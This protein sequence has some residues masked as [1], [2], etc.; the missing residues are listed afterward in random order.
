MTTFFKYRRAAVFAVLVL[1]GGLLYFLSS[2]HYVES[3][4]FSHKSGFYEDEF[5][6]KISAFNSGKIYYTLDGS[7]P[8]EN[9]L[10][11][12]GPIRITD[13]SKNP[14]HYSTLTNVSAGFFT[15]LIEQYQTED[16]VPG[17]K[18]PDFS[19]D[20]CTVVRAVAVNSNGDFSDTITASYFVKKKAS[21]YGCNIISL[22]TDPENLFDD[23]K[24]IYV[25]GNTFSDYLEDGEIGYDWRFWNA[26]Y[27]NRGAEWERPVSVEFFDANGVLQHYQNCGARIH[28]GVSRGTLPRSF[29]LYARM[30][31]DTSDKFDIPL[32][33]SDYLPQ[34][35][36]LNS[37]GNQLITQFPDY[38]MTERVRDLN[39]STMLFSPYVLFINGEYWGFYWMSEKYDDKYLEYYYNINPDNAVM[40]KN[41]EIEIGEEEDIA[42]Y[43]DMR[44]FVIENDMSLDENYNT[45]C[46]LID[47]DSFIDYYATMI[48]ISRREDWPGTNFALWRT[49]EISPSNEY[50][51]GKWRWMLFDCNSTGMRDDINLTT[52]NTLERV[53]NRDKFFHSLW[54]NEN[55]RNSFSERLLYIG[56]TCFNVTDMNVLIDSYIAN[57]SPLLEKSWER[58]YGKENDKY[59]VFTDMMESHRAF[60]NGR[61]EA[62]QKWF[63]Q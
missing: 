37:G 12:T 58:F 51:D 45:A 14:N 63:E 11:Y 47:I 7:V 24:G 50:S 20:K 42:L 17:Y 5:F 49:R 55:F 36:T 48:Y 30:S 29:N 27:R 23:E 25:T 4:S 52:Y 31:Y 60:F 43:N 62:V 54:E 35:I 13:A 57:I 18:V 21:D 8:N 46:E 16:T 15:E 38:M 32:F 53:I 2:R 40:I 19:V 22:V 3:P 59:T 28:G 56:E 10:C 41:G 34:R 9:S 44:A 33:S 61:Y 1:A 39:I 26:N 6:L